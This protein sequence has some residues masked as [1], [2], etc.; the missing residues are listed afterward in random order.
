MSHLIVKVKNV[1]ESSYDESKKELLLTKHS[2]DIFTN[3]QIYE[4]LSKHLITCGNCGSFYVPGDILYK[5]L[6][7]LLYDDKFDSIYDCFSE[8]E[9]SLVNVISA[10]EE[11]WQGYLT[12][13]KPDLKVFTYTDTGDA[14]QLIYDKV[15]FKLNAE[16]ACNRIYKVMA[17]K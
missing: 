16:C 9:G 17:N 12:E 14:L 4:A 7:S 2:Y 8:L 5:T 13:G 1:K 6:D 11:E 3:S 15:V 10:T